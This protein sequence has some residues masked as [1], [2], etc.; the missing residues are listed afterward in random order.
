MIS[1]T[2][3]RLLNIDR[4]NSLLDAPCLLCGY[5]GA[6]YWEAG[7]RHEKCP[8][9]AVKGRDERMGKLPGMV[10]EALIKGDGT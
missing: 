10:E 1:K 7:T 9:H 5:D 4:L 6:G 3:K 8:W 2:K